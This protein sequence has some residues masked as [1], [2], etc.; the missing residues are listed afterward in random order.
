MSRVAI[1]LIAGIAAFRFFPYFPITISS[2]CIIVFAWLSMKKA[3]SVGRTISVAAL[4]FAFG[5]WYSAER[6]E[7]L[8]ELKM[9]AYDLMVEGIVTGTPAV[10]KE[11]LQLDLYEIYLE[12]RAI[13]G[14]IR[15]FLPPELYMSVPAEDMLSHGDRVRALARLKTP[16]ALRNPGVYAYDLKK[17][18]IVAAGYVKQ[19]RILS[20]GA[21]AL[22]WIS[23]QR[24]R[25]G[26][27]MDNSL[28][29]ENAAFLKAIIPGFKGGISQEMRDAFGVTGLAH[30]LSISGTHFGLMAFIVFVLIKSVMKFLPRTSLSRMTLYITPTQAAVLVTLPVLVLYALISGGSTPTIRSL[31]MVLIY[32]L[33]LLLGRRGQ[34]INSLSIAAVIILLWQPAALFE[35]SFILS[36]LAVFSIGTVLDRMPALSNSVSE[37]IE[38]GTANKKL[39]VERISGKLK[40]APLLTI[41]AVAGTAPVAALV[42]KQISLISPLTNLIIT[43]LVCFVILPIGFFSGFCALVFDMS[44]MPFNGLADSVTGYVLRLIEYVSRFPYANVHLHNPSFV[45]ILLY[46]LTLLYLIRFSRRPAVTED[47]GVPLP[48]SL[49]TDRRPLGR[50]EIKRIT[51]RFLPFLM[52]VSLYLSIPYLTDKGFSVTFLDVGQGDASVVRLPGGRVMLIDGGARRGRT[53]VAPYLWSRGIRKLDYMVLSHPHP[54]HYGGLEYILDKFDVGEVWMNGRVYAESNGFFRKVRDKGINYKILSRGD[55]FEADGY[56]IHVLH[57]YDEFNAASPQGMQPGENNES[58]VLRIEAD[59]VS[60]LFTGDIE[61]EA[62]ADLVYLGGWLAVDI[63]K[64][65]HHGSRTSSSEAFLRMVG[66]QIAVASAGRNNSFGHPHPDIVNRFESAGIKFLRTDNSGAVT[67]SSNGGVLKISTY[68]D[69]ALKISS[70]RLDEIGNLKLLL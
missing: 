35:L 45:L 69:T 43:P 2:L 58:L 28:S 40:T 41:A 14:K 21:G 56:A 12:G 23:G 3:G 9:P 55:A 11:R 25:L 4:V 30:L 8:P 26:R 31:V 64:V 63:M 16:Y 66:P 48:G 5:V 18:G 13:R 44:V 6:Y 62:E 24:Q 65:P 61:K 60:V 19:L 70:G 29:V 67:I 50:E 59:G 10:S 54:D 49:D 39:I 53:V 47:C 33:A 15:L 51:R 46:Y 57:P 34:W 36:F 32:M 1:S 52:V 68:E 27:I 20:K 17:D 22:N 42:F 37:K 38:A 7:V